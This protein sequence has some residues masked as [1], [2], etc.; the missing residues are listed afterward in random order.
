MNKDSIRPP[1]EVLKK[2]DAYVKGDTEFAAYTR[3]LQSKW[4]EKEGLLIGHYKIVDKKPF[5][6]GN[7]INEPIPE[8]SGRNF[9]TDNIRTVVAKALAE[10]EKGAQIFRNRLYSNLLSSQPLAFNLF[11]ELSL[12]LIR[13]TKFFTKLFPKLDIQQVN[14]IIFEH[15]EG[16][17]DCEYTCDHS[18]FDVF[19]EY[20]ST[21]SKSGFIGI[22][23]K[24]AE[25]LRDKT[26]T[27]KTRYKELFDE[28]GI[29]KPDSLDALR[30]KPLQQIWRDHLLAIAHLYHKSKKY[31][32][33]VFVYLFP[34][35]NK[36]CQ[37]AVGS[38]IKH[39]ISYDD[40]TGTYDMTK[41]GFYACHLEYFIMALIDLYANAPNN[42]WTKKLKS[43]YLGD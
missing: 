8:E 38:Y 30:E 18:A 21:E 40:N 26:S 33:G 41:T 29:F 39:F 13:A 25:N 3:L 2:Y 5:Y 6:I 24:Y 36:Q 1:K 4:R 43:R 23:V 11:G 35:K 37:D 34:N 16:R 27:D 7:Y 31:D 10:K 32:A 28:S 12:D 20:Q 9:I 19:V 42:S 17:G 22:E 14:K 15:S